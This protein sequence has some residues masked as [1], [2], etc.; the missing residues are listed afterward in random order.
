MKIIGHRGAAGLALENTIEGITEGV[1]AG[2]DFIELDVR[3]TRDNKLIVCHDAN[4][5]RTYGVDLTINEHSL[6]ELRIPC[7]NLPTLDEALKACQT[8]GVII[9]L[10][11]Y[12]EPKRIFAITDKHKALIIRFASFNHHVI[13]AIKN[14]RPKSFCYLLEHHSPFEII[15]HARKMK[16]D[17]IG[18]NYGVINP[19]SYL[20]AR[21]HKLHV[22]I[23]TVNKPWIAT[24]LSWMYKDS[25]LC[26]DFPNKMEHIKQ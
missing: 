8:E 11:E 9:E 19:L 10:K 7:P 13:R 21:R 20:L 23:Y 16:A 18:L 24:G 25:Y 12:I 3:M 5:K 14:L 2:A 15:N 22:Y 6:Q 17:G 1:N 4:L 26:T